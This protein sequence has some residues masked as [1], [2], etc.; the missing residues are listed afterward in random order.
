VLFLLI[1][2][3]VFDEA[4]PLSIAKLRRHVPV[5]LRQLVSSLLDGNPTKRPSAQKVQSRLAFILRP[6]SQTRRAPKTQ[7]A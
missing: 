4:K 1:T 7:A 2:G 3:Q 6:H 5:E